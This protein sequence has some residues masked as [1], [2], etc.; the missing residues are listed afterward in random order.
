MSDPAAIWSSDANTIH[1]MGRGIHWVE[2]PA[3]ARAIN[4]RISGDPAVNW[5][6]YVTDR[7][8]AARRGQYIGLSLGCGTGY[9]ERMFQRQGVFR[10]LIG[11][12]IAEGA[13]KLCRELAAREQA[14]VRYEVCDLNH[15]RLPAGRYDAIIAGS[16]LHHVQ[17]LEHC[18]DQINQALAPD[19]ILVVNEYVGPAQFQLGRTQCGIINDLLRCLPDRYRKMRVGRTPLKPDFVPLSR[20]LM[21]EVDP[22]EAIRSDEIIPLCLER[23]DLLER[24]DY[25]GTLLQMLLQYIAGNFE[26]NDEK[27]QAIINLLTYFE[28]LLIDSGVLASDF[29]FMV[30]RR[31]APGAAAAPLPPATGL[32]AQRRRPREIAAYARES[33]SLPVLL[34]AY[35]RRCWAAL[36]TA[37]PGGQ[38]LRLAI[39]GAG[40]HTGWLEKVVRDLTPPHGPQVAAILDDH[41]IGKPTYWGHPVNT[42]GQFD[43]AQADAFLLST[44]TQTDQLRE[45]C[46]AVFGPNARAISFY[47]GF[48]PGPYPK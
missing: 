43:A 19:G 18:L 42:P 39:L 6:Q 3:I 40:H 9:I 8:L 45:R 10:E 23:F 2:Q 48:P 14:A 25:G 16:C 35:V 4:Q 44:D 26:I 38:P 33:L 31:R 46:R 30:L 5:V 41:P 28:E 1:R 7:Y 32:L 21:S 24:K 22:S 13:L 20:E 27:D 36:G 15:C 47:E 12:D 29:T 11:T 17:R 34:R 37:N